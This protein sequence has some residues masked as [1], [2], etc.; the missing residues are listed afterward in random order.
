MRTRELPYAG[1]AKARS[2]AMRKEFGGGSKGYAN[3]GR[4]VFPKMTAGAVTGRG[5]LEKIDA[6]GDKAKAK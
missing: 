2:E 1:E 5:R 4:V 3:G 6:Y